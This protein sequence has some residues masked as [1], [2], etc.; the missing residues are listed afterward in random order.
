MSFGGRSSTPPS[1]MGQQASEIVN[2]N[3][4]AGDG[5]FRPGPQ[6]SE[7]L[8]G[9]VALQLQE[10][11]GRGQPVPVTFND[12]VQAS[13]EY[14]LTDA[15]TFT[16]RA[17]E[18]SGKYLPMMKKIFQDNG[19]PQDLVYLALIE[20][21]YR[22]DAVSPANAV[23]PWQFIRST[24][25]RYGL[26]I[27]DFVD[28]RMHPEKST[29]AAAQYLSDLHNRFGCW[30]LA[31]AAYNAGEGKIERA[32]K[33]YRAESF[34]EIAEAGNYLR[35]ETKNYVPKFL[36]IMLIA[37]DPARYGLVGLNPAP[38]EV[39]DEVVVTDPTD[40]AVVARL[41]RTDEDTIKDLNPHLK[42][43]CTPISERNYSLRVPRGRGALFLQEYALLN[44]SKR[45]KV[46]THVARS[47][48]SIKTIARHY[49]LSSSTLMT[50]NGLKSSRLQKGQKIR[51]PLDE[52]TYLARKKEYDT[53][54]AAKRKQLEQSGRR[55]IYTVRTGDTPWNIARNYD[56]HWKEIAEW[57]NIT[58]VKKIKPGQKLVLYLDSA[59]GNDVGINKTVA[60]SMVNRNRGGTYTVRQGDSVW[61]IAKKFNIKTDELR[62]Y[63]NLKD[64][65]IRPGQTL[66]IEAAR[67]KPFVK[68][69]SFVKSDQ[70]DGASSKKTG[71]SAQIAS[72]RGTGTKSDSGNREQSPGGTEVSYTVKPNDTL[73]KISQQFKVKPGDIKQANGMENNDIQPG[74]VLKIPGASSPRTTASLTTEKAA[75]R[76]TLAKENEKARKTGRVQE[77]SYKVKDGDTLWKIARLFKVNPQEIQTWNEMKDN[78]IKPGDILT[79]KQDKS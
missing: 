66:V 76:E 55:I 38:P 45:M 57:N 65:K 7:E 33:R 31:A 43:W 63:N 67:S 41:A 74:K 71:Q 77:V 18:R 62:T 29:R 75:T 68:Q 28:E 15:R 26:K 48:E 51:L 2:S 24:G 72:I 34:W 46:S 3:R 11:E 40:L 20:S 4:P 59:P 23:G 6:F 16:V 12:E 39:Y 49:Q 21:G 9:K 30:Q 17:L 64:D 14:F 58:D 52:K 25:R 53:K 37:K 22:V 44:P 73:W 1:R 61:K 56:L 19:L 8:K 60:K 36:A 78:K 54:M 10:L 13:L 42:L 35:P 27:N 70:K 32:L 79:I 69:G 5:T 47:G 50:F